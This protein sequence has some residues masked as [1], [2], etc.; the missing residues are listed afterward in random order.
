MSRRPRGVRPWVKTWMWSA[1]FICG[2]A[3]AFTRAGISG[4][5]HDVLGAGMA[6]FLGEVCLVYGVFKFAVVKRRRRR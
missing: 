6:V 5:S 1:F 4:S 3:A 2:A